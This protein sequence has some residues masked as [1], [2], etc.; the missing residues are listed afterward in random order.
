MQTKQTYGILFG[1]IM[2]MLFNLIPATAIPSESE[3]ALIPQNAGVEDILDGS[4]DLISPESISSIIPSEISMDDLAKL[5][6]GIGMDDV[7]NLSTDERTV[8]KIHIKTKE[9]YLNLKINI[10]KS[11]DGEIYG[12]ADLKYRE[13]DEDQRM[14][15]DLKL[16][17]K[18]DPDGFHLNGKLKFSF[19]LKTATE[20]LSLR[21]ELDLKVNG[22]KT[23]MKLD[24][25]IDFNYKSED[26]R[27]RIKFGMNFHL[28]WGTGEIHLNAYLNI[29]SKFADG[30]GELELHVI[31]HIVPKTNR[32]C[33]KLTG[34]MRLHTKTD[35]VFV[36]G[37]ASVTQNSETGELNLRMRLITYTRVDD[38]KVKDIKEYDG[39]FGHGFP[40]LLQ[41]LGWMI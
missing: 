6:S 24:L 32:F 27:L 9:T 37:E 13:H 4:S 40:V 29:E 17:F 31:I 11:D 14:K 5:F 15:A 18:Y 12:R 3:Q 41:S 7:F 2:I 23:S 35:S 25:K 16:K 21:V 39:E 20:S 22:D 36:K 30:C 34:S 26:I 1:I 33:A 8:Y 28:N 38:E 19:S 10:R